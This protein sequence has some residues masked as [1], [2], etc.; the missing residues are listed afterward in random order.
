MRRREGARRGSPLI[1]AFI[2]LASFAAA[3]YFWLQYADSSQRQ[4]IAYLEGLSERLRSETVPLKFMVLSRDGGEIKARIR[5]YD[6][7]GKEVAVVEK[8]W[9]GSELFIDMLLVPMRSDEAAEKADSWLAFP[10]R[11]FTDRVGAASGTLL[12]DAYDSD[13]FPEVLR[14]APWTARDKAAIKS[15]FAS[16]RKLAS[17]G[18]PASDSA[19]GSFGSAVHEVS[20]LSRFETEIIYKVVCRVKG[21]IEIMED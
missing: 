19:K 5:L 12:F 18:L 13:G 4:K 10:Y 9:L 1:G 14:G 8:S 3:G 15:A 11:V 6:L 21:G 7:E 16:A 20:R 17:S 2:I